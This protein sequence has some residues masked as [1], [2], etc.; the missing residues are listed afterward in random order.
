MSRGLS[1]AQKAAAAAPHRMAVALVELHFQAGNL[2]LA[3]SPW[4]VVVNGETYQRTGAL[5]KIDAAHESSKSFEGI[6]IT[7]S[8]LDASIMAIAANEPYR[9]R[10][11]RVLKVYLDP[12]SGQLIG[13]PVVQFV[14]RIRSMPIQEKND[15]CTVA[16]QAEHYEA[17]LQ[18][19]APLRLNN[20]DQQRLYPGDKGAEF[21]DQLEDKVVVWPTKKALEQQ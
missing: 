3:L 20:A 8:G 11:V 4:D 15:T 14:G 7:M 2:F 1:T 12:E 16:V 10:L 19:A 18:R 6:T 17:E 5:M 9:G 21:A 13:N